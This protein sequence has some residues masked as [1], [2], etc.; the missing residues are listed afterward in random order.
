[1]LDILLE[2]MKKALDDFYRITGMQ[3]SLYDEME[4][5]IYHAKKS[6][7]PLCGKYKRNPL[8]AEKCTQCEKEGYRRCMEKKKTHVYRC[9]AGLMEAYIPICVEGNIIGHL[10][11]GQILCE[12]NV[13]YARAKA[14]EYEKLCGLD[15]PLFSDLLEKEA[16]VDRS[17]LQAAV[18][19]MEMCASY[20]YL[21]RIICKKPQ[22]L[23]ARVKDYIDNHFTEDITVQ[24]LCD[25]M[26][27]SKA[28]LYNISKDIFGM[29]SS[30]YILNKRIELAK[31]LLTASEKSIYMISEE[32]GFHDANYFARIF[33]KM[34]GMS[35]GQYRK[36][37]KSI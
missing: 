3:I 16:I 9:H 22:L 14:K 30:E 19:M 37:N 31:K 36:E 1:M 35:P 32:T 10:L 34:T 29:G 24:S 8:V 20:L 27:I 18:N 7:I 33:K 2:D 21:N 23:S 11:T 26:Y 13:E 25:E 6:M 4:N 5:G 15:T 17:Y 12:E 28:K